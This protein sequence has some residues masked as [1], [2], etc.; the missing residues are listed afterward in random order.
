MSSPG[1][2]QPNPSEGTGKC[3][4]EPIILAS[5]RAWESGRRRF[6]PLLNSPHTYADNPRLTAAWRDLLTDPQQPTLITGVAESGYE[7]GAG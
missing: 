4:P 3:N 7:K 2:R 1:S 6:Q 5:E